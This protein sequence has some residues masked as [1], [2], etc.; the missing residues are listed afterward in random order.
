VQIPLVRAPDRAEVLLSGF[1]RRRQRSEV[2]RQAV[3][4]G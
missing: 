4:Q 3:T 1:N 2:D